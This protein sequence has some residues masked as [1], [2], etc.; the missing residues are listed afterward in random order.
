MHIYFS[1]VCALKWKDYNK[2]ILNSVY[3][4]TEVWSLSSDY[5][6]GCIKVQA[7]SISDSFFFFFL[8]WDS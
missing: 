1:L 6:S 8:N 4:N 2:I 7:F 3:C 5:M